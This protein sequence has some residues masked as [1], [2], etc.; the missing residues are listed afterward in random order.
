[1]G[2]PNI[3]VLQFGSS[4]LTVPLRNKRQQWSEAAL[5]SL[6]ARTRLAHPANLMH[7]L[8][9][10]VRGL[11]GDALKLKPVTAP[12]V[13]L[14]AMD[15]LIRAVA[16]RGAIP[17][18]LSPFVLGSQRSN[19]IA[20]HCV[21]ALGKLVAAVPNAYYVEVFSTL[22]QFPRREILLRDGRFL[23][24]PGQVVVA[25]SLFTVLGRVL[26]EQKEALGVGCT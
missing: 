21:P 25:E 8:R 12:E 17:I 5:S 22:E 2:E 19:R 1:V 6:A 14:G 24:I 18:V 11:I 20:R 7:T 15:Y 9:W 13:Y 4:D 16:A 10:R 26:E 23:T 3:V